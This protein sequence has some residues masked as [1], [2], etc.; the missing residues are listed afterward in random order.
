M[1]LKSSPQA[2]NAMSSGVRQLYGQKVS[3]AESFAKAMDGSGCGA[4]DACASS[5][6]VEE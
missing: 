3:D 5:Q 4:V 6:S 2:Q 1:S